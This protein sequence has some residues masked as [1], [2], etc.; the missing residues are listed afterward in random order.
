VTDRL[1]PLF[2]RIVVKE[3]SPDEVRQSGLLVPATSMQL[4][5]PPQE[6]VVIEV[7]PGLDWWEQAGIKMPVRPGDHVV[8][9]YNTGNYVEINE[10]KLLVMR[11]GELLGVIE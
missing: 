1:K 7:G 6:G 9:T 2:D 3:L 5:M 11:V 4:Q 10:E 8:F